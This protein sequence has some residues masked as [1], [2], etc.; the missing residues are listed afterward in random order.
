LSP[1]LYPAPGL[2]PEIVLVTWTWPDDSIMHMTDFVGLHVDD[3]WVCHL[4]ISSNE[5][6]VQNFGGVQ[7][8]TV[9]SLG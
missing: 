5:Y 9:F 6:L 4:D 2:A 3:T 8:T 7:T 1:G